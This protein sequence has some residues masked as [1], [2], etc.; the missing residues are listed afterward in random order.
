MRVYLTAIED[1]ICLVFRK[2]M[3]SFS[4]SLASALHNASAW[5][6]TALASNYI[7]FGVFCILW[8]TLY[9]VDG[10]FDSLSLNIS[11]YC[12]I[13]ALILTE[14]PC[15]YTQQFRYMRLSL[16]SLVCIF[17]WLVNIILVLYNIWVL[18]EFLDKHII[19]RPSINKKYSWY[20]L[21]LCL[22][23]LCRICWQIQIFRFTSFSH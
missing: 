21:H 19:C 17:T 3:T 13:L 1:N 14:F 16:K 20:F 11:L 10:N 8:M 18:R 5:M 23:W 7:L 22:E 4:R 12:N 2:L 9:V 15:Q 6:F